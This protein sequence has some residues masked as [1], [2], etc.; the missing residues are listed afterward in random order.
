MAC[1]VAQSII[2][3]NSAHGLFV[4]CHCLTRESLDCQVRVTLEMSVQTRVLVNNQWATRIVDINQIMAGNRDPVGEQKPDING[5][6]GALKPPVLGLLTQTLIKSPVIRYIIPARIRHQKYND[7]LLIYNNYIEIK[8]VVTQGYLPDLSVE[9]RDI[10][11][12]LDFDSPIRAARVFGCPRKITASVQEPTGIDAIVKKEQL[13]SEDDTDEYHVGIPPQILILS[14]ESKKLV[15]LFA[16]HD[17]SG[18]VHFV[19][20][21]RVLPSQ[22][23]HNRQLGES[24]A[25]DPR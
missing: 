22:V 16:S 19:S 8:E 25:V 10:A 17:T 23:E 12:K 2:V 20:S 7:V 21:E 6:L 13:P 15:F 4:S 11:V 9:L 3:H 24:I 1:A 5:T 14:L 18:A